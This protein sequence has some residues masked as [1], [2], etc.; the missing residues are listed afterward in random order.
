MAE[1]NVLLAHSG[2]RD[3]VAELQRLTEQLAELEGVP[4]SVVAE[5]I[6]RALNDELRGLAKTGP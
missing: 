6:K 3:Q 1:K 5:R 4:V 2:L